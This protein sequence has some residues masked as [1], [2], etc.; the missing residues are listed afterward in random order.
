MRRFIPTLLCLV[1]LCA[2]AQK[3][4]GDSWATVKANGSG[5]LTVIYYEQPGLI[6][7]ADDGAM[8][9]VC[10]D[11]ISDFVDYVQ[12][13]YGKKI[14]VNY[15]GKEQVFTEFLKIS[16]ETP[17]ILGVTNTSITT[18]RKK[19]MKFTPPFMSNP[20]V[21]LTHKDAPN[22]K[23]LEESATKFKGFS[24]VGIK[25]STHMIQIE[26]IKRNYLPALS[27]STANSGTEILRQLGTNQKLF[28]VLDFAE[29]VDATRNKLPVKRQAVDLGSDEDLGF[30]MSLKSDWDVIWS[31]FLTPD[32]RKS[33][34]YKKII[35]NNLGTSFLGII[36]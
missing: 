30:I 19:A 27:I 13:K 29:Y 36:K 25:G 34:R 15:A 8:K 20:L 6:Y 24:A 11:I 12:K 2:H 5:T 7:K 33:T 28:S 32:Y 18:E 31:E 16:Q 10:A 22:L 35:A 21:L 3:Y 4:K 14:T 9:G 1:A 23:V 17:N 26:R